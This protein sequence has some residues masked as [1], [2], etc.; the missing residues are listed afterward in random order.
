MPVG[1]RGPMAL[2]SSATGTCAAADLTSLLEHLMQRN[3]TIGLIGALL[4]AGTTAAPAQTDGYLLACSAAAQLGRGCTT[5]SN[6]GDP[7]ALL[8]NPAGLASVGA[9]ALSVNGAA[10]LPTMNYT[11]A[12]NPTTVGKD[13]IFPLPAVFFAD[14]ARGSWVFGLGAQ[15]LGGMGADYTLTHALLGPNQRYHSKFGLMKGGLAAAYRATSRLSVGASVGALFGQIEFATPYAVSP[16]QLAG[17]AGLAQDPSYAP[18]L[19]GF[20]EATAYANMTGLS[21]FG[22][23]AGA[24]IQYQASPRVTLALAWTAPST[25][26]MGGGSVSMDMNAQFGQLYQGMVAAKG[27]NAA[28]VDAQLA[29]FGINMANGMA[30]EFGAAVDFGIPQTLTLALGVR[31]DSRWSFGLDLGYIGWK[32]AFKTMP[33]RLTGG[34]NANVNIMMNGSPTNGAFGSEWQLQWKDAWTARAGVEY[35]ATA[36]LSLRGGAIYGTNPVSSA[37][38][39]TIFP[40]IVQSAATLGAGYQI[41]RTVV[42]LT[43]AHTFTHEQT[44]SSPHLVASEY[45]NSCSHLGETT[46]SLGLGWRF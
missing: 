19:G 41:G 17:L 42:N 30:S 20:T 2:D 11:N 46:F 37:G 33:V 29:G 9:R 35:A 26:T 44:A 23:T 24:S 34:T 32:S 22:F 28:V 18:M 38:L 10:F 31:P 16:A 8:A 39:F 6:P 27:G 1:E 21:G 14:R 5:L 13:N 25:L 12:V 36:V 15:T 40:A 45:A 4:A 3:L 7:S 43:Y